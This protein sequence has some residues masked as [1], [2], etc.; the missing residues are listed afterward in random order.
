MP[1]MNHVPM[2]LTP[3]WSMTSNTGSNNSGNVTILSADTGLSYPYYTNTAS[4][5]WSNTNTNQRV[6]ITDGDIKL[7]GLSVRETMQA[8]LEEL[9]C[10]NRL[11]R[12][13]ELEREWEELRAVAEHYEQLAKDFREKKKVWDTLNSHT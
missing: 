10:P 5:S 3:D 6:V 7:D 8:I 12:H 9:R 11:R 4:A 2:N 13:P 1:G